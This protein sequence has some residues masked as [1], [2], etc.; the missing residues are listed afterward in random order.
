[1][2]SK[3]LVVFLLAAALTLPPAVA[4]VVFQVETTYH[5]GSPRGPESSQM[6]VEGPNLKMEIPPGEGDRGGGEALYRGDRREVVVVDHD[7]KSYWV[8]NEETLGSIAAQVGAAAGMMQ[9]ALKNVPEAERRKIEEMMKQRMPSAAQ[10]PEQQKTELRRTDETGTKN[11]YPCRKYEVWR[12]GEKVQ[13]LWVT[14]WSNVKGGDEVA[15]T[16]RE[17]AGFW[18]EI[19]D[20]FRSSAGAFGPFASDDH[21]AVTFDRVGGFPVV[22]RDFEGGELD[23][24][25]VL[26]SVTERDLDPDAFEPPKGYR[27]RTMGPQ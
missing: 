2:K 12:G 3:S 19:M 23:S 14:D 7:D 11:G 21:F 4:G 16:F 10:M 20:S 25:T 1:M 8:M 18:T 15:A 17:M 26:E 24:E 27:L 9:E 13:E 22:T 6:S 5:S